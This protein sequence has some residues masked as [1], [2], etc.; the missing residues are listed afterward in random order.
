MRIMRPTRSV[1]WTKDRIAALPTPDVRQLRTNAERLNDPEI[2]QRCDA[3]LG[4]RPRGGGAGA[5]RKDGTPRPAKK[6]ALETGGA[7]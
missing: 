5:R 1:D 7:A 6:R 3:V 4:E 2:M